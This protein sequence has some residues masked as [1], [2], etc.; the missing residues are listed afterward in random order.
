M[1]PDME[2]LLSKFTG[3]ETRGKIEYCCYGDRIQIQTYGQRSPLHGM[4]AED[5]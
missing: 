4:F 1:N 5:G 2:I 3:S